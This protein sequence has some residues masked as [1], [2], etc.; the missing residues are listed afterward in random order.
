[1]YEIKIQA[2]RSKLCRRY[3]WD[4]SIAYVSVAENMLSGK[5]YC[6]RDIRLQNDII[7]CRA[8]LDELMIVSIA[9]CQ[10]LIISRRSRELYMLKGEIYGILEPAFFSAFVDPTFRI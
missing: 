3:F 4:S 8:A 7:M 9:L 1:M 10:D 6:I 2:I 5:V